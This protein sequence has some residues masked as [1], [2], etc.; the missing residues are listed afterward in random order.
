MADAIV[1]TLP[2]S[3]DREQ[4]EAHWWLV[5]DGRILD[6]GIGTQWV[7]LAA[8]GAADDRKRIALAPAGAVRIEV[9]DRAPGL[10]DRQASSGARAEAVEASLGDSD[11]LHSASA[12]HGDKVM[13]AVVDNGVML[14]WLDWAREVNADPHHVVPAGALLPLEEEWTAATFGSERVIG[15]AGTVMPFEPELASRIVGDSEP[16]ELGR[17]EVE[18][19]IA[20]AAGQPPLDLRTGKM[21]RRRRIVIDR[22]RIRQLA[23]LAAII[24]LISVLVVLVSIAKINSATDRLNERTLAIAERALGRPVTL[25]SAESELSQRVGGVG[26]GGVMAPLSGLYSALQAEQGVST[27]ELA[28]RSD[29]TLSATLAAPNVDPVNRVLVALQRNGYRITA[30]PRQAPDGRSMVDVTVRSGL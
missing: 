18:A 20:G 6:S 28:Y 12:L 10:S 21:A 15:R 30:V 23:I 16:R 26:H 7:E 8:A 14:A 9:A 2:E 13:T 19:A 25:E 24:P 17:D 4:L 3:P 11:A 1:F 27:T 5:G 29:G 22:Q